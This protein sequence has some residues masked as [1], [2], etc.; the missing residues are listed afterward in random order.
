MLLDYL[1]LLT[2]KWW[3]I[4]S[5]G[6]LLG[7]DEFARRYSPWLHRWFNFV[8]AKTRRRV[9]VSALIFAF[10]YVNYALWAEAQSARTA[11]EARAESLSASEQVKE[12]RQLHTLLQEAR[13]E[14]LGLKDAEKF[15]K[16]ARA[17]TEHDKQ[18]LTQS[19]SPLVS[20]F[21][22]LKIGAPVGDGEAHG[23]ASEFAAHFKSL[24]IEP[25]GPRTLQ[26][27]SFSKGGLQIAV[28]DIK[29]IPVKAEIFARALAAA[30]FTPHLA[31]LPM[32]ELEFEF[33]VAAKP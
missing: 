20:D 25:V 12:V 32:E 18:Q 30:G 26:P 13:N 5:A 19:L 17:L 22:R 15:R 27:T 11:A 24:G 23:F 8:P 4:V 31:Q 33:I 21:P 9:E 3:A 28:N 14:I 29:K 1:W 2:T 6:A 16:T 10:V 7:I